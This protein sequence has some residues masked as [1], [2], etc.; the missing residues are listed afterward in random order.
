MAEAKKEVADPKS[1]NVVALSSMF[2]QDQDM[3]NENVG[4][5]D[6]ATPFLKI[7]SG[8]DDD[9]MNE[10]ENAKKGDIYNTVNK[11]IYKGK[12]G[13]RVIPCSYQVRFIQWAPRGAVSY[14][15]LRAHET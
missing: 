10:N 4:Q 1:A 6:L 5:E 12:D 15:H 14:T 11:E 9:I 7:I 3:G 2:E 13:I 8:Q